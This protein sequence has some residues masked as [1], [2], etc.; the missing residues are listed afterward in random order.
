M[1]AK[2]FP[3]HP[4]HQLPSMST[5]PATSAACSFNRTNPYQ[6]HYPPHQYNLSA[7]PTMDNGNIGLQIASLIS[8]INKNELMGNLGSNNSGAYTEAQQMAQNQLARIRMPGVMPHEN[9]APDNS[10]RTNQYQQLHTPQQR[11][12]SVIPTTG[13]RNND[14][15]EAT[16][17][18]GNNNNN[19]QLL[20]SLSPSTLGANTETEQA[21]RNQ[22]ICHM[23]D[24]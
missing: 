9:Y 3:Q 15:P 10:N 16:V 7:N 22:L 4:P 8:G 6:Q 12:S 21:D 11:Y 2:N 19:E 18:S 17:I 5:M 24:I 14:P 20:A 23:N 1:L 13:S